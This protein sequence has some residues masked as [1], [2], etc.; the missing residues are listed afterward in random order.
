M[1]LESIVFWILTIFAIGVAIWL[2]FGSPDFNNSMIMIVIFVASSGILLWRTLFVFDNKNS[3]KLS[4]IDKKTSLGFERVK[5]DFKDV[6]NKLGNLNK[7][8]R[9]VKNLVSK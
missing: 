2:A 8:V 1:R 9:E 6:N 3:L 5:S 4:E 7:E